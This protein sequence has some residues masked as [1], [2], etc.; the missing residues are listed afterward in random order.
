MVVY[1]GGSST[2]SG[3][4]SASS[5]SLGLGLGPASA[6]CMTVVRRPRCHITGGPLRGGPTA[7]GGGSEGRLARE[8]CAQVL[9]EAALPRGGPPSDVLRLCEERKDG[10][11]AEGLWLRC[12]DAEEMEPLGPRRMV[13]W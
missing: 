1:A 7:T 3:S 10:W 13:P 4:G 5:G 12:V 2:V 11:R 8:R 6:C 9:A